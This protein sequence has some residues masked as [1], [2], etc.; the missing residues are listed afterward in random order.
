MRLGLLGGSF[1]P[2]HNGHLAIAK[3]TQSLLLLDRILFIPTGDP[4][5]K[6]D[7]TLAP[8]QDRYEM[9]RLAISAESTF[10]V[11][12][13]EIRRPGKSYTLDT[14]R[15]LQGQ[16]GSDTRLFF[17]IGLDAFLDFPTWREPN[18]LLHLCS[19]V[20]ISRPGVS[21]EALANMPLLPANLQESLAALD[22]GRLARLV[23][24]LDHQE[25]ICLT[26]TP[27]N[28]SASEIRANVRQAKPLANLLPQSVES[29]IIHHHLY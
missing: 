1:N 26:L 8:A 24:P 19:F 14:V 25:L 28:I 9:V 17:L 5:H 18:T 12:D 21:F 3:Q 16:Y 27:S 22:S 29:Y 7:G 6:P 4:P 20:V 15:I 13:V 23:I 11:S 2:I 10:A